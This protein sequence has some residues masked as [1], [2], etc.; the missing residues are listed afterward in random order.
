MSDSDT[1]NP[2]NYQQDEDGEQDDLQEGPTA[3]EISDKDSDVLSDID[4]NQFNDYDDTAAYIEDR[5]VE[6]DEDVAKS[7]KASK[8]KRADG[9]TIKKPKENRRA[10]KRARNEDGDFSADGAEGAEGRSRKSRADGEPPTANK[11]A[12]SPDENDENLTPEERRRR[13]IGRAI[14][15]AV[16]NPVKRRRKK[17][18]E[19]CRLGRLDGFGTHR[20]RWALLTLSKLRIWKMRLTS[21]SPRSRSAWNKPVLQTTMRARKASLPST[22][23]SYFPKL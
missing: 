13:A 18:E 15:A 2:T 17:D 7:L 4:E 9:D 22:N 19:V 5:P 8:R 16:K 20:I 12:P 1:P 21:R 11:E 14:D 23:S 6:I 10:R 3:G